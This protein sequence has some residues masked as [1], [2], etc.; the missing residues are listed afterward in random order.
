MRC[1]NKKQKRNMKSIVLAAALLASSSAFAKP[2]AVSDGCYALSTSATRIIPSNPLHAPFVRPSETK[3]ILCLTG[4][5]KS[6]SLQ[7][8]VAVLMEPS[9]R[10]RRNFK[11]VSA[12][13]SN[14]YRPG[15][16]LQAFYTSLFRTDGNL[17]FMFRALGAT[18]TAYESGEFKFSN[19]DVSYIYELHPGMNVP[20]PS[21]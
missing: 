11:V 1:G 4:V 17:D 5:T 15:S 20:P 16:T 6:G 7:N 14:T 8:A 12:E 19:R 21:F 9:L 3:F 13:H 2:G 18:G 10:Q